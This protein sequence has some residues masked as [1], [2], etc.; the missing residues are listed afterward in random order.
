MAVIVFDVNETL[1]DLSGLDASFAEA[2]GDRAGELKRLWFAR[3]VHTSAVLTMIG[4]WQDFGVVG[5]S[6]LAD[7]ATRVGIAVDDAQVDRILG[8]MTSLEPH[9][10]VVPGMTRLAA[11][12]ARL[13]ALTNSGQTT[14]EAQLAA[15]GLD[16]F[17]DAILSVDAVKRFKPDPAV[18]EHCAAVLDVAP[19]DLLMVA[20]HDWDCAGAMRAGWRSAFLERPGQGYNRLLQPPTHRAP[21]LPTLAGQLVAAGVV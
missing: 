20:A 5:R 17:L 19:I 6:V 11:A 3:L 21:D 7:L 14:A 15:A 13:V 10:D 18:Y 2:F 4:S 16:G 9:P 12:G 8:Q 1:L